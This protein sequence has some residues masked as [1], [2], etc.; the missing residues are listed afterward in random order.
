MNILQKAHVNAHLFYIFACVALMGT[1]LY[2]TCIKS[3]TLHLLRVPERAAMQSLTQVHNY[4]SE[5][6]WEHYALAGVIM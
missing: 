4:R 6:D 2:T 3:G 5:D 1:K